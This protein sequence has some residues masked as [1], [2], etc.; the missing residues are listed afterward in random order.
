MVSVTDLCAVDALL[1][2]ATDCIVQLLEIRAVWRPLQ[3]LYEIRN[4]TT[5]HLDSLLTGTVS[6]QW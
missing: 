6:S 3:R 1:Q 2:L 5:E 4:I